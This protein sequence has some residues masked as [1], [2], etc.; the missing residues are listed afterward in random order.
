MSKER[1]APRINLP[2]PDNTVYFPVEKGHEF[3]TNEA[4]RRAGKDNLVYAIEYGSQVTGDAS[5]SSKYDMMIVVDDATQFHKDGL[6]VAG[7]DYAYPHVALYHGLLN[8]LGFNFYHAKV[9]DDNDQVVGVK[10]AVISKKNFIKGCYGTLPR[11]YRQAQGAFGMYVAG[12]V[13]KAAL[14][15]LYKKEEEAPLIESAINAARID[16]VWF[17]LASVDQRFTYEDILRAYVRGSYWTDVRVEKKGKTDTF[18][19][20]NPEDYR[21]ILTPIIQSMVE[22]GLMREVEGGFEKVISMGKGEHRASIARLKSTSFLTNYLKNPLTTGIVRG[23]IYALSKVA[24]SAS[25]HLPH[26][27]KV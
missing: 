4:L 16:G 8:K 11:R 1:A 26:Q 9:R 14:A 12:R 17:A 13:Q 20:K 25:S 15:P 23:I 5:K 18:I 7:G 27:N 6:K 24:R 22:S 3:L 2:K 21:E 19:E 10:L